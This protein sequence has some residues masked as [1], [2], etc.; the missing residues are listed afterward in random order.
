[1]VLFKK[2]GSDLAKLR[3]LMLVEEF[4]WCINSDVRVFLNDKEVENWDVA[5]RLADDYSLTH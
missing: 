3:Q 5:A 4:K 1:M 2:L